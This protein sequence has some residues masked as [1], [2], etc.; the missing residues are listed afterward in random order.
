M[1]SYISNNSLNSNGIGLQILNGDNNILINNII[2]YNSVAGV[3]IMAASRSN[4]LEK[5]NINNNEIG[6]DIAAADS[7]IL[8]NN[9]KNNFNF[10][11]RLTQKPT[12]FRF[13]NV[14]NSGRYNLNNNVYNLAATENYWGSTATG[15]IESKFLNMVAT[16]TAAT[17]TDTTVYPTVY[18]PYLTVEEDIT[19]VIRPILNPFSTST[20]AAQVDI[21]GLKPTGVIVFINERAVAGETIQNDSSWTYKATLRLGDNDFTIYYQDV[22]GRKGGLKTITIRKDNELEAPV[23]GSYATSTSAGSIVLSGTKPAGASIIINNSEA[24]A[25]NAATS[26]TYNFPLALGA[27]SLEILAHS[28]NQ[29][30]AVINLTITRFKNTVADVIA[31]EK[32]LSSKTDVKLSLRLAGRLLLQVETSGY[33]WYVNPKDNLRYFVSADSALAIFRALSL[34]IN[35]ANLNL[36]PTKASGA[37]GNTALRDRLKG[38]FL[39]R[40]ESR[41]QISYVDVDGYRNDI[42]QANLMNIFRGLSL[43]ISNA[44]LRKIA[45][46]EL[47]T[48]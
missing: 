16:T 11:L 15:V 34:G 41:G 43:G 12:L 14:F 37:K 27:N 30:S 17:T 36:I 8:Q 32:K 6:A 23:I 5:N 3:R 22:S 21:S 26:W 44:D 25:A 4:A 2:K 7:I 40:T 35:E 9:I 28:G 46:G 20:V 33:I 47:K 45:I 29:Y 42:S 31:Q 10:G 19:S 24:V 39:L 13:N 1:T 38:R 18:N 48:E